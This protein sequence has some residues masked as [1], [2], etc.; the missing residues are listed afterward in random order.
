MG[1]YKTV[2]QNKKAGQMPGFLVCGFLDLELQP[3]S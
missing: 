2:P 1:N 3:Y